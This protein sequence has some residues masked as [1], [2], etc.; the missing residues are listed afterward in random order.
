MLGHRL[1]NSLTGLC[2][3]GLLSSFFCSVVAFH[4]FVLTIQ[5]FSG[6]S[7][8]AA[9]AI[10][11]PVAAVFQFKFV[12]FVV[13]YGYSRRAGYPGWISAAV[14]GT[15]ADLWTPNLFPW[16]WGNLLAGDAW[17]AQWAEFVGPGGLT[18]IL[19]TISHGVFSILA[20]ASRG[21]KVLRRNRRSRYAFLAAIC[22]V[23]AVGGVRYYQWR[24]LQ[25]QLPT[26]RVAI[27]QTNAPLELTT[28]TGDRDPRVE[29]AAMHIIRTTVPAMA[30]SAGDVDLLVLPESAVPYFTTDEF[31][32]NRR[33]RVYNAEY[34]ALAREQSREKTGPALIL[35]E[36]N[37]REYRSGP[38][39][40]PAAR[41]HNSAA[42]YL[43]G[44]RRAEYHKRRLLA[45]GEYVPGENAWRRLGLTR[46]MPAFLQ[47][48]RFY[49]GDISVP[50]R[51]AVPRGTPAAAADD[52]TISPTICYEIIFTD[53]VREALGRELAGLLVN[54][55]QDGWYGDTIETRQHFELARLRSIE[56]RR[57][58]VRANN[59]GASG[60]VDLTGA[61]VTPLQGP[62][63]TRH[64]QRAVQVF[65]V[66]VQNE[67]A[68]LY[69][70]IG[71]WWFAAVLIACI[72][73]LLIAVRR[74]A[75]Q[76]SQD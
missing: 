39:A 38:G 12:I 31:Y 43:A 45:F 51:F 23:Y 16:Y 61:F 62:T 25:T 70:R 52:V 50:A 47:A 3:A 44:E 21:L 24:E 15:A 9:V 36:V 74:G 27:L 29:A 6:V 5:N 8:A 63:L 46:Y 35:N 40:S 57:A 20:S 32:L 17:A 76:P 72:A 28:D 73:A 49:P 64:G 65:D 1:R 59:N 75:R 69:I 54:L 2:A 53:H 42:L 4:W 34:Q 22:F 33:F 13:A 55:T 56:T 66:P 37:F 41:A 71:H 19:F 10:Y 7:L 26:L 67:S 30:K 11:L 18:F 14:I 68:T 58:L 48:S 60:V